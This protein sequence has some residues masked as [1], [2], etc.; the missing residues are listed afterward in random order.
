VIEQPLTREGLAVRHRQVSRAPELRVEIA[1]P[2]NSVREL[3]EKVDPDLA[4]GATEAWAVYPRTKR[5]EFL[6]R[7]GC[8]RQSAFAVDLARPFD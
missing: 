7:G 1:S 8:V 2:S 5:F 3:R 4:A 6:D